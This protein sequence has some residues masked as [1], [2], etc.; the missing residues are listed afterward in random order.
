MLV[1]GDFRNYLVAQRAGM[2][3]E[4]IPMLF[5]TTTN[6]PDGRRGWFAWARVGADSVSDNAFRLLQNQ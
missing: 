5:S 2:S 4:Q 3:V 1:V 6:L